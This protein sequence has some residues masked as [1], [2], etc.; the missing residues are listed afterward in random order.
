[1]FTGIVKE[2]GEVERIAKNS[3]LTRLG[4][5]AKAISREAL[6]S[7]SVSVDGVCLTVTDK[8]NSVLYFDAIKSTIDKTNLKR[9]KLRDFVNLESALKAGDKLGG[10]FV[11]GHIDCETKIQRIINKT[12]YRQLEIVLPASFR[13]YVIDNGS[14]SLNGISLTIKKAAPRFFTVDIIPF[15]YENTSLKYKRTGDWINVEFDY[16]LKKPV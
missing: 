9:L 10:H 7:D 4:I 5:R 12:D 6:V 14:V 8:K 2:I 15:T 1:M 3:A 16:L 11:L 13:K